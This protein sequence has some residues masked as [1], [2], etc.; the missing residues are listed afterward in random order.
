MFKGLKVGER[1]CDCCVLSVI[2]PIA[3]ALLSL[4]KC[5]LLYIYNVES[6]LA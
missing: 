5:A 3:L 2:V 4:C 1:I 6:C